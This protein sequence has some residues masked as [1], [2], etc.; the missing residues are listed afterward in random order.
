M[1]IP[2]GTIFILIGGGVVLLIL[3]NL[4]RYSHALS[5]RAFQSIFLLVTAVGMAAAYF[6]S[7]REHQ[8]F[9]GDRVK[10]LVFPFI[11]NTNEAQRSASAQGF[12]L[13]EV[14]S[15]TLGASEQSKL[16]ILPPETVFEIADRDSLHDITY[17]LKLGNGLG[18]EFL[19]LGVYQVVAGNYHIQFQLFQLAQSQ[20]LFQH[21][22]QVPVH[23]PSLAAGEISAKILQQVG[24]AEAR[25]PGRS[26]AGNHLS[27]AGRA[28]YYEN[29]FALLCGEHQQAAREATALALS[30][31]SQPLFTVLAARATLEYLAQRRTHEREWQ[32]SLRVW[33]PRLRSAVKRDSLMARGWLTLGQACIYAK[34]W[35]DAEQS[36]RRA[37]ALDSLNSKIY[38]SFAQL[39]MSRL[40]DLTFENELEL[41]RR[42]HA[43][44][45]C[46][47]E[48]AIATSNHLLLSNRRDEAIALLER[49][50]RLNPDHLAVLMMLGRIFVTKNE[51]LQTLPLFEHILALDP[52]NAD[53]YYNLGI[54]YYNQEN[55]TTAIRFFERALQLND[56]AD[57]RLYLAYI[58]ERRKD[59]DKAIHYLRERIRLSTGDDDVFAGEARKHLYEVLLQRGEIPENL[60]PDKLEKK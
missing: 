18:V 43:L 4:Y 47:V 45:P 2:L 25:M 46:D 49:Y 59:M 56:H 32:D 12:A 31:T 10:L 38:L 26:I 16:Q 54:A 13:A 23:D 1:Q 17:L 29:Y 7:L 50:R 55:D 44:N 58:Y 9:A 11:Q 57:A 21:R 24:L 35:N 36:L 48:A 53:A 33:L 40:Q 5:K 52:A 39:H 15:A 3:W 20:P 60:L 8:R 28:G 14:V 19:G 30:D 41:C 6:L 51:L 22:L 34:K 37:R 27:A 42:A